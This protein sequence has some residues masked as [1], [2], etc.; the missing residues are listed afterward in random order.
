MRARA[1]EAVECT[2]TLGHRETRPFVDHAQLG[3][4]GTR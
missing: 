4:R 2:H 3:A 1:P